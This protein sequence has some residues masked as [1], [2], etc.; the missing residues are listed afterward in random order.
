MTLSS[1]GL[2]FAVLFLALGVVELY[3]FMR[4]VHPAISARYEKQKVTYSQGRSPAFIANIIRLQS[5]IVMPV[6]GYVVGAQVSGGN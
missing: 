3:I 5:L 1:T 2:I 6:L 4:A